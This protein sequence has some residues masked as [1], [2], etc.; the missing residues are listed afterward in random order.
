MQIY[1]CN[2]RICRYNQDMR[3][4][5]QQVL[6]YIQ[7]HRSVT[8]RDLSQALHTTGANIRHHL[9]ILQE[10]ELI[11]VIGER[12]PKGKGRPAQLYGPSQRWLGDNLGLLVHVLLS[13]LLLQKPNPRE[14]VSVEPLPAEQVPLEPVPAELATR[15]NHELLARLGERLAV[16][17]GG[18]GQESDRP[19]GGA[20]GKTS[21]PTHISRRLMDVV[22]TLNRFHYHARWEAHADAPRLIFDHCPYAAIFDQHPELCQVDAAMVA[23]LLSRPVEPI[24][25]LALDRRGLPH[26]T[27]R[28]NL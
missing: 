16:A 25:L 28:I 21:S 8:A 17:M 3:T 7:A 22:Q 26:C 11:V 12:E 4:S 27:F 15:P 20:S 23:T 24:I 10:E 1:I 2:N 6:D 5:R 9:A 18:E 19:H 13:E 14:L